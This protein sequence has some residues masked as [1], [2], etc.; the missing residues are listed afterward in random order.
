MSKLLET[1]RMTELQLWNTAERQMR[2]LSGAR[3]GEYNAWERRGMAKQALEC[4][5]ELRMRGS[6]LLIYDSDS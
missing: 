1:R 3:M 4:I 2:A 6:Q 5:Q